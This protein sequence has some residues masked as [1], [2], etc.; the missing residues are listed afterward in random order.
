MSNAVKDASLIVEHQFLKK[1]DTDSSRPVEIGAVYYRRSNPPE[2]DWERDYAV[3]RE[4]GHTMFRHWFTWNAVHIAPDTF[5]WAP[6]DRHLELAAKNG[7]K[8]IIAEH[9][10]EAPDWLYHKYPH[11]RLELANGSTHSSAM[12]HSNALGHTRM[13]LDNEEVL[14]EA[15]KF[16]TGLARHYR[17]NPGLYG[18]DIWNECSLYNA[19]SLCY[20]P[21]TRRSFRAWLREKYDDDLN[22]LRNAWR[23]Y[24]ITNWDEIEMPRYIQPYPDTIDMVNFQNDTAI[25]WMKMRQDTIRKAD[26]R[27]FIVAHGN[28]KTFCDIPA[29]G[30]DYRAGEFCDIYGYTFWYGNAC[31]TMLGS[32]MIR[33]A[34]AGKEFWRAEAIG[35]S[36]WMDRGGYTEPILKQEEMADPENIR[37]DAMYSLAAGSRGFIN[38]RW[39]ALQDG[40]LFDGYGW[41]NLD[42]SRSARSQEIKKLSLWANDPK[43]LPLWKAQPL[44]G[45]I[46]LLLLEDAEIFCYSFYDSTSYYSLAYQGAYEAFLDAGIQA[47]PI[48]LNH[49]DD[50]RILYLPFPVS[51]SDA[52]VE[53]LSL[54]T[55]RGG[56]LI[57]EGCLGYFSAHG[58]AYEHQPSRGLDTLIGAKQDTVSFGPDMWHGLEFASARG[59]CGGGIYRQTYLPT[60]GKVTAWYKDGKAAV[61][62]N[63]YGKGKVLTIGS[64]AGYGYKL[65][66][67][68]EY[69]RFFASVLP[70]AGTR[71]LVRSDYNSGLISRVW[72][73]REECFLWCVNPRAYAQ[74]AAL[75]LNDR[76]LEASSAEAFRGGEAQ[77]DGR[78]LSFHVPSK[79]AVVYRLK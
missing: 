49:I 14:A 12:G 38:P 64:M 21:A 56:A 44:R 29:C 79:D 55:E 10:Y 66:G 75:E 19:K 33:I 60:T 57:A 20:C 69:L 37:L 73:N 48:R 16:L 70:F 61:V 50:Y 76:L 51:L 15:Q 32:D 17:D 74:D 53:K 36:D 43:V 24:S 18:Y 78:Y 40:S 45:E 28:A 35:N 6:Y 7:I 27:N 8:T 11:A 4:D 9:V 41:Y 68:I 62:E 22:K 59:L 47:D 65:A 5:D 42:G 77:L 71:P 26:K 46:G 31:H 52:A 30:D 13:C 2:Y 72:A 25:K 58:H 34:A 67:K 63:R 54:W 39:R 23:R 1:Y 3:A